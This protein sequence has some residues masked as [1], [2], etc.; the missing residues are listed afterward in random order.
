MNEDT[1]SPDGFDIEI[2][3]NAEYVPDA[4]ADDDL[5]LDEQPYQ[6]MD[7]LDAETY[8]QLK[9]S[10]RKNGFRDPVHVTPDDHVVDGH[11]RVLAW[12]EIERDG[13]RLDT[14][15]RP[16]YST[17]SGASAADCRRVAW[18]LNMQQRHLD[19]GEKKD[20]IERR[21]TELDA[22]GEHPPDS[23]VAETLG[24]SASWVREVR[25]WL[26]G[27][28]KIRSRADVTTDTDGRRTKDDADAKR[29][30]VEAAIRDNPSKSN[31][32]IARDVGVSHPFVGGIRDELA[33]PEL[34][35]YFRRESAGGFEFYVSQTSA[36]DIVVT[37]TDSGDRRVQ[38]RHG[39]FYRDRDLS[40]R[41]ANEGWVIARRE[42][43]TEYE[44][45]KTVEEFAANT[46]RIKAKKE[47]EL[48]S[49]GYEF[50]YNPGD[51]DAEAVAD[52]GR[53]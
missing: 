29:E 16:R 23:R 5:V 36:A 6:V 7:P 28:G 27:T 38:L 39:P 44:A 19:D 52:G 2:P 4:D 3:A 43:G 49:E 42:V 30:Q 40:G 31:R 34:P 35:S 25:H 21:L 22:D 24:V 13:E 41:G 50:E 1:K 46:D 10:I 12:R 32:A 45:A 47:R 17:V 53:R 18:E 48:R 9:T 14:D 37:E 11:H 51:D 8:A 26:E 20:A 15:E 33:E